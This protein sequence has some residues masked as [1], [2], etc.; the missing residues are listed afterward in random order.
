MRLGY[1]K[2]LYMLAFDHRASFSKNLLGIDGSPSPEQLQRITDTKLVIYDAFELAVADG[3]E[4]HTAGLLVDEHYGTPVARR[5]RRADRILAMPVEKSGQAE[6]DFEFGGE[7]DSHIEEFDPTFA[8]VLVRYNP[9]GDRALNRRQ[10]AR[11]QALSDWLHERDRKFLFELLVPAEEHQLARLTKDQYDLELRPS[12][13]VETMRELQDAGVE[14]DIWKIEGFER[15]EHCVDAAEQARSGGRDG[16]ICIVLGRGAGKKKV[17]HWLAQGAGVP[18]YAGFAVGRT[19]W[20]D[21]LVRYVAGEYDRAEAAAQ[22]A[23][24][25]RSLIDI[26]VDDAEAPARQDGTHARYACAR[27]AYGVSV[28]RIPDRCPMC[29]GSAWQEERAPVPVGT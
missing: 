29:G 4:P 26:Y 1:D 23:R 16:V 13:V 5:A 25:Y 22:I 12:L 8:K 14:P 17:S 19:L 9:E 24:N 10:A 2:H 7:F 21:E 3:V 27:C 18:G 28:A 15:R 20:W 6:F 11:L